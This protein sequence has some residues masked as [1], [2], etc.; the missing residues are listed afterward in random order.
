[1]SSLLFTGP[2]VTGPLSEALI[3][4]EDLLN[5]FSVGIGKEVDSGRV[6][7]KTAQDI[8]GWDRFTSVIVGS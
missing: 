5:S 1:M 3:F 2:S 7:S 6:K 4:E 8:S